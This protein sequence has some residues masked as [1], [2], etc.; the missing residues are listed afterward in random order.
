M[1]LAKTVF[2]TSRVSSSFLQAW[3]QPCGTAI[4]YYLAGKLALLLAIPPGYATAVW[5]PSGLAIVAVLLLGYRVWPGI[6]CG[7]FLINVSTGFD[8]TSGTTALKS[9][10]IAASIGAGASLQAVLG[11]WLIR[12]TVG[13]SNAL[14]R[15]QAV[16][17]FLTLAGPVSCVISATIGVATLW[18]A[19]VIASAEALFHW[20]TWW[21]GDTIGVIIFAPLGLIWF[22]EPRG[23]WHRRRLSVSLP[24]GL[25]FALAVVL[26]LYASGWE[27]NRL[28]REFERRT[29]LI[30]SELKKDFGGYVDV[31]ESIRSFHGSAPNMSRAAFGTFVKHWFSRHPGIQ[32]LEWAPRI[33]ASQRS[34]HELTGRQGGLS[35]YEIT[36]LNSQQQRERAA[37]RAEYFPIYYVEP[38]D[39]NQ[40]ALGFDGSST[41]AR[42]EAM[43][44]ARDSGKPAATH[45]IQLIQETGRQP[46]I[47]IYLAI[48]ASGQPTA[49]MEQRRQYLIGYAIGAFRLGDMITASLGKVDLTG[50]TVKVYDRQAPAETRLLYQNASSVQELAPARSDDGYRS[51]AQFLMAGRMWGVDVSGDSTYLAAHRSWQAWGVLAGGLLLT[52]LLGA[53]LLVI[54]GRTAVVEELVTQRTQELKASNLNLQRQ[55]LEREKTE[56]ILR[57]SEERF[58]RVFHVSP[59]AIGIGTLAEGRFIEVNPAFLELFGFSREE[60]IGTTSVELGIWLSRAARAESLQSLNEGEPIRSLE[61]SFRAKSGRTIQTLSSAVLIRLKDELCVVSLILDITERKQGEEIL[62]RAHEDLEK[63]VDER[64]IELNASNA[65]LRTQILERMLVEEAVRRAHNELET[66]VEA[67]TAELI[68]ANEHLQANEQRTRLIIDTAQDAFVAIDSNA[69]I[70]D[71]NPQAAA[72]FG[73]ARFEAIGRSFAETILAA[74]WRGA[75]DHGPLA[76]LETVH[77]NIRGQRFEMTALRRN[78]EELPVELSIVPINVG[79]ESFYC[80]FLRDISERKRA[81]EALKDSQ[82]LYHSLVENLPLNVW[83]KDLSGHFTF[84]NG[85]FCEIMGLPVHEILG[86]TVFDFYSADLAEKYT[87]DDQRVI[88]TG[89]P[90]EDVEEHRVRSAEPSFVQVIKTPLHNNQGQIA[91]IQGIFTDVTERERIKRELAQARDAALESARLKAEFLAN[92]SHEIR[93]PMNGV[94]GMVQ[95]IKDTPLSPEQ[96]DCVEAIDKS[97]ETLLAII[98]DILDLSKIEAGKLVFEILD[99]NLRET[100]EDA[101]QLHADT[102]RAKGLKIDSLI[103]PDVPVGLRGDSLRLSQVLMNLIGNAVKFTPNGEITVDV[104]RVSED[105]SRATLRFDVRDTGIGISKE[106]RARLFQ[107]FAQAD[108][109]TTRKYGGSGLGLAIAKELV[110]RMDGQIDVESIPGKGSTFWF[111]ASFEKQVASPFDISDP[112]LL[113]QSSAPSGL[114]AAPSGRMLS[115]L[116]D[117]KILVAEDNVINQKVI[118]GQLQRLGCTAEIVTNGLEVM[119]AL[120]AAPYEIILMDCQM[121]EMDGYETTREIRARTKEIGTPAPHIIAVTAHAMKGDR[122][123]CL[124]AGMDDYI[125]KP[126]QMAELKAVLDRWKSKRRREGSSSSAAVEL[127]G[128]S[129]PNGPANGAGPID[130]ALLRDATGG[131]LKLMRELIGFFLIQADEILKKLEHSIQSGSTDE[132]R[133]LAHKLAGASATCGMT[134]MG[135]RLREL[136]TLGLEGR[137]AGADSLLDESKTALAKIREFLAV[138]KEF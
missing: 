70:T 69:R 100:V 51:S 12:R 21:V 36:V 94:I 4:A 92:M 103:D 115:E 62:R 131:D 97:A 11:G 29:D 16:I 10:A 64:T 121:P 130:I 129:T 125:A 106:T 93:T 8:A 95:L 3:V 52:G 23:G 39:G 112:R 79:G 81:E 40:A 126:V 119:R 101:L 43:I 17:K 138:T 113:P 13:S 75:D 27:A 67:R 57:Q 96:R 105:D 110:E 41:P 59:I 108:G 128:Q 72:M 28:K 37:D 24:L 134:D 56:E 74:R 33:S 137:I 58:S 123:K 132:M 87:R 5:P 25:T 122:E 85:K 117:V 82:A 86:K 50:L 120:Q 38:F 61:V 73:W 34:T 1:R 18:A 49:T 53:F 66:R 127:E 98:N 44:A 135:H 47:L 107:A 9:L 65:A 45:R 31:L 48:Y 19:S 22:G 32:A 78:A 118:V 88:H 114:A 63:R 42:L 80:A 2:M 91:G 26:F 102:A 90:F 84:A 35:N 104:R 83:R 14:Y 124:A 60:V 7:S 55:V 6:L 54:T 99:F 77:G 71:W 15:E 136:E 116:Q 30:T 68:V 109:S 46:G 133:T 20:W 89:Q 76:F 111:T